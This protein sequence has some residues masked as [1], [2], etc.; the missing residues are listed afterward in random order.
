MKVVE[1]KFPNGDFEI[2]TTVRVPIPGEAMIRRGFNGKV[3]HVEA[4]WPPVITLQ[5]EEERPVWP[6]PKGR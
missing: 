4:G 2:D 1:F 5:P 6:M 3:D